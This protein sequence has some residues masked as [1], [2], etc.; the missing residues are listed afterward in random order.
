MLETQTPSTP[1][2][3]RPEVDDPAYRAALERAE[4]VQGFYIHL[5]VFVIVNIGLFAI[6]ALTRADAGT[7]WFQWPLLGWGI[8]IVVHGLAT[9]FPVFQNDWV[10]RRAERYLNR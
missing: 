5:T 3:R 8:G 1:K 4:M 6:N 10:E 7:W 9:A 2:A